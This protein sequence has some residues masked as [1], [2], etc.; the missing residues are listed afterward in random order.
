[1][2][3]RYKCPQNDSSRHSSHLNGKGKFCIS[4]LVAGH[5]DLSRLLWRKTKSESSLEDLL[6]HAFFLD[7]ATRSCE[8]ERELQTGVRVSYEYHLKGQNSNLNMSWHPVIDS[9]YSNMNYILV[10]NADL[11]FFVGD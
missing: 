5:G 10:V 4:S 11:T 7:Y 9:I 2:M 8:K 3:R 1:M 6:P